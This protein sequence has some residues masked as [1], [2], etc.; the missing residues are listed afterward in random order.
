MAD[1][2]RQSA[3]GISVALRVTPRGGRD[4]IDGTETLV[5][6][7][8]SPHHHCREFAMRTSESGHQSDG[9]GVLK[10][11]VKILFGMTSRLKQVAVDGDPKKLAEALRAL[12]ASK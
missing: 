12:T 9:R 7:S 1:P 11:R 3:Q 8:K 10:A 6:R 2:W 5:W 4:G